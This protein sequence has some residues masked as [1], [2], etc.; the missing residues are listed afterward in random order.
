[1][2]EAVNIG[3]FFGILLGIIVGLIIHLV[4]IKKIK[5]QIPDSLLHPK[6]KT[7]IPVKPKS[8]GKKK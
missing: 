2:E 7:N 1:M 6:K 4:R 8:K 3:I 5:K